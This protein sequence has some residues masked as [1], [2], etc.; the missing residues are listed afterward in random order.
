M[1][2]IDVTSQKL[3]TESVAQLVEFDF[4]AIGGSSRVFICNELEG[5]YINY[6]KMTSLWDGVNRTFEHVDFTLS[7]LRSDLT[8]QVTEPT[9]TVAAQSLWDISAWASATSSLN[10]MQYRGLKVVRQ[11]KFY[12]IS[13][14]FLKQTLYVKE[15]AELTPEVITFTLT[16]SLGTEN[17]DKPSARK[18]EI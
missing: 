15:I 4:R 9:L 7:E 8:G 13:D 1:S 6:T 16:P 17:G 3:V 11:R 5:G 14:V 18:L 12:N 10:L 2:Q